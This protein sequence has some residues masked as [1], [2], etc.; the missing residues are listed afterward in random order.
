MI[1]DI[2]ITSYRKPPIIVTLFQIKNQKPIATHG[3]QEI[4]LFHPCTVCLQKFVI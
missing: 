4:D 2:I 1:S 3:S